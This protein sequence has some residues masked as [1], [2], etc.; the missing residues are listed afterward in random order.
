[1][2]IEASLINSDYK[3]F[4]L[5]VILS[6]E[7]TQFFSLEFIHYSRIVAKETFHLAMGEKTQHEKISSFYDWHELI[8]GDFIFLFSV[9][10]SSSVISAL[11]DPMNRS[12]PGFPVHHHSQSSL[13]LMS[14]ES[15]MPPRHL[16]LCRPLP[17]SESFPM[18]QLFT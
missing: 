16:I 9:Q 1:M 10:F 6:L 7:F 14:I 5:E 13:K 8:L 2:E 12:T 3:L 11:C 4:F 17:P 15:M 18:S